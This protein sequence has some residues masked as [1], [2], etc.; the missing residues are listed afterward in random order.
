MGADVVCELARRHGA[1][2]LKPMRGQRARVEEVRIGGRR[3]ALAVPTTY[4]NESGNALG[5]L[6]RRFGI[7]DPAAVVVVHDELDLPPGGLQV[8]SGGGLAGHNGLR[9][10]E[11]HLHTNAFLRVRVGIGKPRGAP[12]ADHVLNRPSRSDR[13]LLDAAIERA[14]DAV[15]VIVTEGPSAAMNRF[16][17][18]V[19]ED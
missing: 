6:V 10:I 11:A 8:K 4:M 2:A 14:A 18:K 3:V 15:E 19:S 1:D 17:A 16:N 12:G 9:S 7:E 13:A 5:P